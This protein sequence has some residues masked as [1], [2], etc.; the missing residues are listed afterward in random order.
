MVIEEMNL[1]Q[2]LLEIKKSVSYLK[3]ESKGHQYNYTSSSQVLGSIRDELNKYRVLLVPEIIES[4]VRE[5]VET[6]ND[7]KKTVTYF[8]ELK[9]TMAWVNVDNPS[10]VI[11]VGW[12]SQGVDIAGE[13]GIGKALTYAEKY[14]LLKFFNIPTDKDDPDS[15]QERHEKPEPKPEIEK[16]NLVEKKQ[17]LENCSDKEELTDFYKGLGK[18]SWTDGESDSLMDAVKLVAEKFNAEVAK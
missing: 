3:K 5:K 16:G 13:K 1:F 7:S 12:A 9:M 17:E 14:F 10:E 8:T 4:T 2:K 11:K 6:K 15:F 18:Y